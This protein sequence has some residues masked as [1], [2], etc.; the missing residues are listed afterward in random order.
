MYSVHAYNTCA[1]LCLLYVNP[2]EKSFYF[3]C[4][5]FSPSS[6]GSHFQRTWGKKL[7]LLHF[8]KNWPLSVK[9]PLTIR[10]RTSGRNSANFDQRV[11]FVFQ[12][13]FKDTLYFLLKCIL[14]PVLFTLTEVVLLFITSTFTRV[15]IQ[16]N[17]GTTD[18]GHRDVASQQ[19]RSR[20]T[21]NFWSHMNAV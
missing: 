15:Q 14:L 10:A 18:P 9:C 5:S 11:Y 7:K 1:V 16:I 17:L 19:A 2:L 4:W 20:Y 3:S 21:G 6:A 12:V 8:S 13:F